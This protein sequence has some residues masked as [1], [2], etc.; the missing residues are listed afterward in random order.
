MLGAEE[1]AGKES[2]ELNEVGWRHITLTPGVPLNQ[3]SAFP[4]FSPACPFSI[5]CPPATPGSAHPSN[6]GLRL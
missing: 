4:V 3:A 1:P 5:Q 6:A 2:K